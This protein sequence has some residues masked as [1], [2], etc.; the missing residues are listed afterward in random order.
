M[1]IQVQV[2]SWG[3]DCGPRPQSTSTQGGGQ[4]RVSQ[5]G[6]HLTFHMRRERTTR[7]CWSENRAVRRVSSSAQA[8]TWRIVCRTPTEDSRAE[9]GTYTIQAIGDSQLSFRDVSAYDWQLNES[10]CVATITTTQNFTR[11]G[12]APAANTQPEQPEPAERAC[13]PGAPARV[14]MRPNRTEVPPGGEQCFNARVVDAQGCA[15]RA[16]EVSLSVTGPGTIAGR[17]YRAPSTEG[18]ARIRATAGEL[19]DEAVVSVRTM[20]LSEWI[21][22]RSESGSVGSG[23]E[24]GED[25][26]ARTRARVSTRARE[27]GAPSLLW[28]AVGLGAAL[29]L[30]I[31]VAIALVRRR[32]PKKRGIAGLPGVDL[33]EPGIP[34]R[35]AKTASTPPP[36]KD[37]GDMI[38]PQCHRG[39]PPGSTR[40]AQHDTALVPYRDFA[41]KK[42]LVNVCPVCGDRFPAHIRFCGKDGVALESADHRA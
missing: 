35:P 40:C 38:C 34:V 41:G 28:P 23:A 20:D 31:G 8:G 5:D 30:V 36:A 22:R 2:Q 26:S 27:E 37:L 3:G 6:D 33:S 10:R 14:V 29:L 12:A 11:V 16:A 19:H 13:T 18:E 15:V 21:A 7:G 25:A 1:S 32:R 17:C 39:Y 4:F 9:T 42:E 24:E